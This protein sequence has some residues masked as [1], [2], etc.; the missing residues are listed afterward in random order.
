MTGLLALPPEFP[1]SVSNPHCTRVWAWNADIE[2]GCWHCVCS[3]HRELNGDIWISSELM[4]LPT[5]SS[6]QGRSY[7]QLFPD[8]RRTLLGAQSRSNFMGSRAL[9]NSGAS[10]PFL[11]FWQ[12]LEVFGD[13]GLFGGFGRF[14][15]F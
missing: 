6:A 3:G 15:G 12:I 5:S 11:R 2:C 8:F 9:G 4:G 7:F 14:W 1:H 13:S 10:W